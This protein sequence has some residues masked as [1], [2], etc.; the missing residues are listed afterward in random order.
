MNIQQ[1]KGLLFQ[2]LSIKIG[3]QLIIG[4]TILIL[5]PLN[6]HLSGDFH[7]LLLYILLQL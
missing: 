3:Q 7:E 4:L 6:F 2:P 1:K 5:L